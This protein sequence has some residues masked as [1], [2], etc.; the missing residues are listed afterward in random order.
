MTIL[1]QTSSQWQFRSHEIIQLYLI[2][3]KPL[4][5]GF[6]EA[7][8]NRSRS[9]LWSQEIP[10][11][12]LAY[13]VFSQNQIVNLGH[14]WSNGVKAVRGQPHECATLG[15]IH[16]VSQSWYIFA[17][18]FACRRQSLTERILCIHCIEIFDWKLP[19]SL[20]SSDSNRCKAHRRSS[21]W[22]HVT[23]LHVAVLACRLVIDSFQMSKYCFNDWSTNDG[24]TW[25]SAIARWWC[26]RM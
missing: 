18:T 12:I 20:S 5:E 6:L 26:L 4:E 21:H 19:I 1:V 17:T 11:K 25:W 10:M 24:S 15:F 22:F 16:N 7:K 3:T 14:D 8:L 9:L 23:C 2:F 13:L